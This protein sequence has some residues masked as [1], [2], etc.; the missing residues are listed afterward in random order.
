MKRLIL[1]LVF[2]AV[3]AVQSISIAAPDMEAIKSAASGMSAADIEKVKSM[4][5]GL[6]NQA[7]PQTLQQTQQTV[8]PADQSSQAVKEE[9]TSQIEELLTAN[10]PNKTALTQ[11]GYSVFNQSSSTFMAPQ[12]ADVGPSYVIGP[13]DAF[14][15]TLWGISEGVIRV[16]VDKKGEITLPKAGVIGIAGLTVGELKGFISQVL[17]P[18]YPNINLS[19]AMDG[20]R[21]IRVYIL[22]E[23]KTPGSYTMS[24]TT[25]V[26][27]AL[28]FAKGVTKKGTLRNIKLIRNGREI[29]TI[30][31]YKFLLKGEKKNDINVE[32]GDTLFVPLIGE[33]VGISGNVYRPAIYEISKDSSLSDLFYLAGGLMPTSYLNRI[34]IQRVIANEKQTIVDMNISKDQDLKKQYKLKNMDMVSIFPIYPAVSNMV[35]LEGAVK[36]PGTYELKDGMTVK[37]LIPSIKSLIFDSYMD[38]AEI[39]RIDVDTKTNIVIPFS[40]TKLIAGDQT[41]SIELKPMDRI[42]IYTD[43]KEDKRASINGEVNI[44][45]VYTIFKGEKLSSLISRAGGFKDDAFLP[46]AVFIRQSAKTTQ[47]NSFARLIKELE[48]K[49]IAESSVN[50]GDAQ[51]NLMAQERFARIKSMLESLKATQAQGRVLIAIDI[52]ERLKNTSDDLELEDGD[53]LTIPQIPSIV[54]VVGEVYDSNSLIYE[55]KKNASYY[56]DILGGFTKD[57]DKSSLF[58]VRANGSVISSDK[59]NVQRSELGRGDTVFVPQKIEM[60]FNWGEWWSGTLDGLFKFAATYAVIVA[61]IK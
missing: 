18:Y 55:N 60:P 6:L 52:P 49:Y 43:K 16:T 39:I 3:L 40:V 42:I 36:Q 15:I 38:R 53:S 32:D 19:V 46:G 61:A 11:F 2:A 58:I 27:N 41:Q 50:L 4:A 10:N 44:P 24:P 7:S 22:G 9:G 29:A 47:Q 48:K 5:P 8:Q 14:S 25:G 57:A 37:D 28:Y 45:G 23:V 21:S 56:I 59:Y 12:N 31:L 33:T 30:D 17:S 1:L 13:G 54:S 20:L 35:F 51:S 34:Q 26:F